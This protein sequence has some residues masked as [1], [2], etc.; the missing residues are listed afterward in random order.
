MTQG[1]FIELCKNLIGNAHVISDS[2][3][4]LS[5]ITDYRKRFTGKALAVV[6]PG[7]TREVA[8]IVKLCHTH[9]IPI[10]PQGGNTGL[11]L[12]SVPDTSGNAIVLS[13]KRMNR[14]REIDVANNTMT[15]EA[16]CILDQ[17]RKI[18]QD[19]DH[20][21][22]LSIAS[23]GSCTIGG[24]LA[25]NA[26]GMAVLR[27]GTARELCLGLEVVTPQ[28]D[29]WNGL[30]K[31]RKNNTGYDLR[32]LYIGSEGTLGIITAAVLKIFPRPATQQTAFIALR[33]PADALRLLSLAQKQTSYMVTTFELMSR[34]CLELVTKHFP[35]LLPPLPLEEACFVL[36]EVS[37]INEPE[38]EANSRF[39]K[40][41]QYAIEEDIVCDVALA[42][43]LS[44][45]AAMWALR[46]NISAAQAKEGKNIKHD[47]S[48]PT[49]LFADFIETTDRQLQHHFPGCRMVIFGHLGDGSLHYNVSAPE[50]IADEDFLLKQSEV[51]KVVYDSV[52]HM[53]GAISAEHGLGALKQK[54]NA[55]YKSEVEIRLMWQIK[56]ALDPENLMNPGKVLV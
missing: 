50:G 25:A 47:I 12:G 49:S 34:Y 8:E 39:E 48:V 55:K 36:M 35:Q 9:K 20:L 22:P 38:E 40:L 3:G 53:H 33:S 46:E 42:Q 51:N 7:S 45:R 18:A 44:Q 26:G 56:K 10:V 31:L 30:Y 27:Y 1:S 2:H 5:Y 11:V 54:E 29:I 6:L 41:L 32:D 16:G 21:F 43:S 13:L 17:A 28:G 15:V 52:I 14:I 19:A 23:S 4:M 37:G 24:C